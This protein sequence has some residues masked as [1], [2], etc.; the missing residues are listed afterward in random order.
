MLAVDAE[1]GSAQAA[2]LVSAYRG[3]LGVAAASPNMGSPG[4]AP[5][6]PRR[7]LLLTVVASCTSA[8][9]IAR[10]LQPSGRRARGSRAS[11]CLIVFF[12]EVLVE[13]HA[14]FDRASDR[15]GLG[16]AHDAAHLLV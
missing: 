14:G 12:G 3:Q 6:V 8:K 13:A 5:P 15:A 16:G 10:A 1:H 2:L 9:Q 7:C 4:P 11:G